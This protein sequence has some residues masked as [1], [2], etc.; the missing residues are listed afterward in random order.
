MKVTWLAQA[1]FLF[2]TGKIKI[3][4]DPYLFDSCTELN[5]DKKRKISVPD[6]AYDIA[7]DMILITHSHLDHLEPKT[8]AH[9]LDKSK[10]S[11][12]LLASETAYGMLG[13]YYEKHNCVLLAPHSVWSEGGVTIY[14]VKAEHSERSAVG[15][16]I[17]DGNKTYYVSGDTLYNYDVIDDV[18]SLVEAGVDYAFLPINGKGNNMNARDAADFAYELGAKCAVPVHFGLF[19]DVDPLEFDFED[20][21]ILEPFKET[22]LR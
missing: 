10:R 5:K 6:F 21:L 4:V 12:T 8:L 16:I 3:M 9:F 18:L 14:S 13:D 17:D 15:Y 22:E 1:G 19:D 7:P 11:V 20:S 2:D